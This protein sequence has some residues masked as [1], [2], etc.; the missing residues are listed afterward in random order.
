MNRIHKIT[1]NNCYNCYINILYQTSNIHVSS[2]QPI[3][4]QLLQHYTTFDVGN[5]AY[6][7]LKYNNKYHKNNNINYHKSMYLTISNSFSTDDVLVDKVSNHKQRLIASESINGRSQLFF[8]ERNTIDNNNNN[9]KSTTTQQQPLQ[10]RWL[11]ID[12]D[13]LSKSDIYNK[14]LEYADKL[15][16]SQKITTTFKQ[17]Y[18]SF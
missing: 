11:A 9:D 17:W 5:R 1:K 10:G 15:S 8:A 18:V 4:Q 14:Q 13:N 2:K 6:K 12:V 16:L 7:Q 3:S